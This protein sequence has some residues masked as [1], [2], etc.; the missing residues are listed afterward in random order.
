MICA[1]V[2]RGVHVS[3]VIDAAA[4]RTGDMLCARDESRQAA[5]LPVAPGARGMRRRYEPRASA[6]AHATFVAFTPYDAIQ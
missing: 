1:P 3:A 2:T 4:V 5:V 6:R